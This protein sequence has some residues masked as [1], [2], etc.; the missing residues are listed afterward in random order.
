VCESPPSSEPASHRSKSVFPHSKSAVLVCVELESKINRDRNAWAGPWS[1]G[2]SPPP[3]ESRSDQGPVRHP[4]L[5]FDEAEFQIHRSGLVPS[6]TTRLITGFPALSV[7]RSA[8]E[9]RFSIALTRS[10]T[11]PSSN[12]QRLRA[13]SR[14]SRRSFAPRRSALSFL[15]HIRKVARPAA[16]PSPPKAVQARQSKQTAI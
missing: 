16:C 1:Q 12:R 3:R 5:E 11:D 8:L 4:L 14:D 10:S 7:L 9:F 13:T 6:V 2:I 15:T